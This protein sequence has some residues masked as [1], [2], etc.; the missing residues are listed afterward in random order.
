MRPPGP[1][2]LVCHFM[3][4]VMTPLWKPIGPEM[5]R[6]TVG[7]VEQ[8]GFQIRVGGLRPEPER[9]PSGGLT[10]VQMSSCGGK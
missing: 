7:I 5:N 1:Q 4:D 6:D 9:V 2:S 3:P 8:A 10:G